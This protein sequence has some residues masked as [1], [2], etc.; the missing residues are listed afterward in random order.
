VGN[1][2]GDLG[3][4]ALDS[5][6]G[7]NWSQLKT[8]KSESTR[9]QTSLI[10][11][12]LKVKAGASEKSRGAKFKKKPCRAHRQK[13]RDLDGANTRDACGWEAIKVS[14]RQQRKWRE[15]KYGKKS[16]L[17]RKFKDSMIRIAYGAPAGRG[18]CTCP[19]GRS[20]PRAVTRTGEGVEAW[21]GKLTD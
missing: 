18:G 20:R 17:A 11:L 21:G 15:K 13:V 14:A 7:R 2:G 6:I 5:K 12:Q 9:P 3:I 10:S 1:E 19:E 8:K 16:G 4:A